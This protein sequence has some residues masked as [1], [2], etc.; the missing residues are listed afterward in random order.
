MPVSHGNFVFLVTYVQVFILA[1][2][3]DV[4]TAERLALCLFLHFAGHLITTFA[5]NPAT[6][7]TQISLHLL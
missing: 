5:Y 2:H 7:F 3:A 4:F 1:I 6:L